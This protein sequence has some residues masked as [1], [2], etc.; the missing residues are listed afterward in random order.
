MPFQT[1][2]LLVVPANTLHQEAVAIFLETNLLEGKGTINLTNNPDFHFINQEDA[3]LQIADVRQMTQDMSLQPY[4]SSISTFIIYKIDE[5]SLPAQNALLKSLEEPPSHVQI[6]L[7]TSNIDNVLPTIQS[8]CGIK[9]ISTQTERSE[10]QK[11]NS[12][13]ISDLIK[14]LP[15]TSNVAIFAISE[16]YKDRAE[17]LV[18]LSQLLELLHQKNQQQPQRQYVQAL[19]AILQTQS[20]VKK[21]VNVRLALEDLFFQLKTLLQRSSSSHF[22]QKPV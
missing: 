22:L 11:Q 20:L 8:R 13:D 10:E 16:K 9:K 4:Q 19:N 18:F 5:A 14:N 2:V 17:A 12:I 7:T 6:I 15:T 1:S 21:N 3:P